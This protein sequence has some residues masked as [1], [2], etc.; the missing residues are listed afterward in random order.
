MVAANHPV[1]PCDLQQTVGTIET[2]GY[3]PPSHQSVSDGVT[4]VTPTKT[5]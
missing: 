5:P 1:A 3:L 2:L 4:L